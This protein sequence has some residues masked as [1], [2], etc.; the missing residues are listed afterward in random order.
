VQVRT[1][2][3]EKSAL[4]R[5]FT[6]RRLVVTDVS[7]QSDAIFKGQATARF[8]VVSFY[9]AAFTDGRFEGKAAG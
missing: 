4:F 8:Y 3:Y 6:Q 2:V 7:V 1:V 9:L 5:D